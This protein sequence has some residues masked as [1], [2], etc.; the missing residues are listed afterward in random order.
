VSNR[1]LTAPRL[2]LVATTTDDRNR[3]HVSGVSH[4]FVYNRRI[5][6]APTLTDTFSDNEAGREQ[7]IK[8]ARLSVSDA[9]TVDDP[10]AEQDYRQLYCPHRVKRVCSL[11]PRQEGHLVVLTDVSGYRDVAFAGVTCAVMITWRDD[12]DTSSNSV[13]RTCGHISLSSRDIV[14]PQLG[15]LF[16]M[17]SDLSGL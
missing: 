15:L 1:S 11:L 8:R 9:L 4:C 5:V 14:N 2:Q 6:P 10:T 16:N 3:S 12:C 7:T 17:S 13:Y